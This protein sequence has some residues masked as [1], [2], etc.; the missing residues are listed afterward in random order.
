MFEQ[1]KKTGDMAE[2]FGRKSGAITARL[3]HL[4]LIPN[5]WKGRGKKVS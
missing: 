2:H 3:A 5:V 1:K 4:G